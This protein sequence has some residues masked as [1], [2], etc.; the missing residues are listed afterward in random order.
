MLPNQN[1]R[2]IM[3]LPLDIANPNFNAQEHLENHI[4]GLC[5]SHQIC[6]PTF[7][8]EILICNPKILEYQLQNQISSILWQEFIDNHVRRAPT[9]EETHQ[10][11][12][13]LIYIWIKAGWITEPIYPYR[14]VYGYEYDFTEAGIKIAQKIIDQVNEAKTQIREIPSLKE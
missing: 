2:H 4:R 7:Y 5:N 9:V 3:N 8:K 14:T 10:A 1:Q 12:H 13:I 6:N 11:T